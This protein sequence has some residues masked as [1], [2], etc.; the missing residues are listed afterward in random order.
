MVVVNGC[1][2]TG[3]TST[4]Y[5]DSWS[6]VEASMNKHRA[7]GDHAAPM[8]NGGKGWRFPTLDDKHHGGPCHR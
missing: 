4:E 6:D 5:H 7:A 3:N 8:L 2:R 1:K